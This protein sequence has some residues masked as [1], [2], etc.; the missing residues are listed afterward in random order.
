MSGTNFLANKRTNLNLK[1]KYMMG[2]FELEV[3]IGQVW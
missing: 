2:W 1:V 3:E